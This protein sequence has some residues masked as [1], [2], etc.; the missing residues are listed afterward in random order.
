M[1][2]LLKLIE[3]LTG[4]EA[5]MDKDKASQPP[6]ADQSSRGQVSITSRAPYARGGV[7]DIR[8]GNPRISTDV[9]TVRSSVP[10]K[11]ESSDT[12]VPTDDTAETLA[13]ILEPGKNQPPSP[14]EKR[15]EGGL[16]PELLKQAEDEAQEQEQDRQKS[17]EAISK[18]KRGKPAAAIAAA[19]IVSLSL[20]G[21][22]V[23]TYLNGQKQPKTDR[24]NNVQNATENNTVAPP[25][26]PVPAADTQPRNANQPPAQSIGEAPDKPVSAD[27]QLPA[28]AP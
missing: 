22:A 25:I 15:T 20:S 1:V 27:N 12:A 6:A 16:S 17:L 18:N 14:E 23:Y 24:Y 7:M 8:A 5:Y 4:T 13:A 26:D 10:R 28:L 11:Q 19:V 2:L 9:N 21:L 3:S